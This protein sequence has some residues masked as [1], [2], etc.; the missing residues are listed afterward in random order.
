MT[1][2]QKILKKLAPILV[3]GR[4]VLV[5]AGM[6]CAIAVMLNRNPSVFFLGTIL[7]FISMVFDLV[8]GWF[9]ERFLPNT[10]LA[11]LADRMM[12]RIVYS[13][14]FP[15]LAAGMMWRLMFA[16]PG[17]RGIELV[18]A[19]FVLILCVAVLIRDNFAHFMRGYATRSG[20]EPEL[21]EINR[22]RTII[23]APLGFMLYI[24][25]FYV[26]PSGAPS[27]IYNAFE[28]I[29]LLPVENLLV[30]EILFL[31][32]NFGSMA[33]YSRKYGAFFLDEICMDDN[34]LRRRIL[35]V[36]PNALTLMNALMGLLAVFFAY[37]GKML[38]SYLLLIGAAV[39][40][41]LDGAMARKLGLTE[42]L[43][44]TTDCKGVSFG[45]VLD[46]IADGISFCIAPGWI[47][48][49]ALT[50]YPDASVQALPAGLVA[51]IYTAAGFARLCYFT[52]DKHPIPG[53]FKG[54]PT[55]AAALLVIAPLVVL[56]QP[57]VQ[58]TQWG[59]A[60]ALFAV[61]LMIFTSILMNLYPVRYLHMGRFMDR[62]PWFTWSMFIL[63]IVFVFTPYFGYLAFA[64]MALYVISPI[65]TR[66]IDP[67]AAARESR[68]G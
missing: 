23:A 52:L 18:H 24:Y 63:G 36:F 15:L 33:V 16:A 39:F 30:V 25:A 43:P 65:A 3:Y 54:M 67:K 7:F 26:P 4:P 1:K 48:Y 22:L 44:D 49:I 61:G 5:F 21:Q 41:K 59:E 37:Q 13:I 42:P 62:N 68:N 14:V 53:I 51:I 40:D 58:G 31:I 50:S 9:A 2:N 60:V 6:I 20:Q 55:P 57:D 47:F 45:A 29:S 56:G 27:A 34:L 12:N 35:S 8:D 28:K 32:I 38:E 46:D 10:N 11:R 19:V 64:L 17:H 66:S